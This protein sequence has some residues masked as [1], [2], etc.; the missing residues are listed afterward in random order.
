MKGVLLFLMFFCCFFSKAQCPA[1]GQEHYLS[2]QERIDAF[3]DAYS[4]CERIEGNIDI[5]AGLV[6]TGDT[7]EIQT[8]ITNITIV[9]IIHPKCQKFGNRLAM[10]LTGQAYADESR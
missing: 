8:P 7:G 2:S 10:D 3:V 1:A 5:V 9:N 6:G 4:G